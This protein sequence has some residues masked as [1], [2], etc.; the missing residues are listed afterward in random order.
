MATYNAKKLTITYGGDT[1]IIDPLQGNESIFI[2][3]PVTIAKNAWTSVPP[4]TYVWTSSYV[5]ANCAISVGFKEGV[6]DGLVGDLKYTKNTGSITFT[7]DEPPVGAIPVLIRIIDSN[8]DGTFPISAE[9][10]ETD[11]IVGC[12]TVQD[13]LEDID[14]RVPG[15]TYTIGNCVKVTSGLTVTGYVCI[16]NNSSDTILDTEWREATVFPGAGVAGNVYIANDTHL[17]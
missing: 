7:T 2:D 9:I 16:A 13:A 3:I 1:Y 12:Y 4:Y 8:V 15:S 11:A 6:R 10:V 14:E 5:T 17:S